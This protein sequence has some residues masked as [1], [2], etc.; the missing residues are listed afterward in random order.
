MLHKR[1]DGGDQPVVNPD[2]HGHGASTYSRHK[3]G[4]SYDEPF[5]QGPYG[6]LQQWFTPFLWLRFYAEPHML[7]REF[8]PK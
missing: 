3:H 6:R 5:Q 4:A 7:G 1:A 2:D 8:H